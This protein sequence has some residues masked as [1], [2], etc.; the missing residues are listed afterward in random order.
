[1]SDS[2]GSP[3]RKSDELL[4]GETGSFP[5]SSG[6]NMVRPWQIDGDS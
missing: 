4:E 6:A 3:V 2:S 1:L 5:A